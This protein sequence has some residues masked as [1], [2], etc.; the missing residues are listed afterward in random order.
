[1][2]LAGLGV[3]LF[4]SMG[5]GGAPFSEW[6]GGRPEDRGG[7]TSEEPVPSNTENLS[8]PEPAKTDTTSPT[9][10][11]GALPVRVLSRH[12]GSP[13]KGA[14]VVVYFDAGEAAPRSEPME[15]HTDAD[16][17]VSVTPP[18]GRWESVRIEYSHGPLRGE[19][20]LVAAEAG[21]W[22]AMEV[23]LPDVFVVGGLVTAA[24]DGRPLEG[25]RVT[26]GEREVRS[27]RLG[28]FRFVDLPAALL[29][30]D[31]PEIQ[32]QGDGRK[33]RTMS[34][35]AETSLDDLMV[36]LETQ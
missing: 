17:R 22:L 14:Q 33:P 21:G 28:R 25:I 5:P 12:G 26:M 23:Y 18:I 1:V 19:T 16:G 13:V 20:T 4:Q 30:G 6:I 24:E 15:A 10:A 9:P 7:A 32:F 34:A 31:L 35:K 36:T 29:E 3:F 11:V 2:A 8:P 27:D